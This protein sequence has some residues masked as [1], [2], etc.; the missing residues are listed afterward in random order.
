MLC[1]K[2]FVSNAT[3]LGRLS[4][5]HGHLVGVGVGEDGLHSKSLEACTGL[6]Q[7]VLV[8]LVGTHNVEGNSREHC[9]VH[10][11]ACGHCNEDIKEGGGTCRVGMSVEFNM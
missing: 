9:G 6:V 1:C 8:S 7:L 3:Y 11:L 2:A 4:C 5:G 10:H